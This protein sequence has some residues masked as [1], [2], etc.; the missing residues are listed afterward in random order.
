MLLTI[1]EDDHIVDI[2]GDRKSPMSKGY[3]CFK[4]LLAE[5]THHDPARL[6]KPLK[7][8]PDGSF[9]TISA[10]QALDEVADKIRAIIA[11]SGP[12][13]VATYTGSGAMLNGTA[14]M[15][16]PPFREALACTMHEGTDFNVHA[17]KFGD[18][19]GGCRCAAVILRAV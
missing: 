15:I 4:G 8:M 3:A 14:M 16:M 11:D 1:D 9:E 13:A 10:E 7:R 12:G 5:E 6:I 17:R 19:V 18:V 2:R